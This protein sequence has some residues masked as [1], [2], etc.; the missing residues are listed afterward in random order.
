MDPYVRETALKRTPGRKDSSLTG[1][2]N[3]LQVLGAGCLPRRAAGRPAAWVLCRLLARPWLLSTGLLTNKIRA[4]TSWQAGN[5]QS[6]ERRTEP[7]VVLVVPAVQGGVGEE[8][9]VARHCLR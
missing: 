7:G 9:Q 4:P 1:H 8:L 3:I 2:P 5:R 6:T